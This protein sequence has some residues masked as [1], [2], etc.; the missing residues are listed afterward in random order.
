MFA[1]VVIG[2]IA[3]STSAYLIETL[4]S[5]H[6][7]DKEVWGTIEAICIALF[8]VEFVL[9]AASCPNYWRFCKCA[10]WGP[11]SLRYPCSM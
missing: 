4:P 7:R 2:A 1:V 8:T 5:Y 11:D 3:V 6:R 9:R 10:C